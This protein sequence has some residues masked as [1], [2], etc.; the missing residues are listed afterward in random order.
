MGTWGK[1]R[2][3]RSAKVQ[4]VMLPRTLAFGSKALT[5][6][7]IQVV[8]IRNLGYISHSPAIRFV[9]ASAVPTIVDS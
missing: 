5:H 3:L 2:M 1:L 8:V 7:A 6:K 4:V 9:D